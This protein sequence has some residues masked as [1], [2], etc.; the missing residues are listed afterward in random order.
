MLKSPKR[1]MVTSALPYANGPLHIGHLTGAY[2]PADIY[3]RYLRLKGEDVVWV[4]GSDEHGAAI[5]I[6]AMK[7][8]LTPREIIDKY[9]AMFRDAFEGMGISFDIFHRTSAPLHYKTSQDFFRKLH[10]KGEFE[11]I[12]NEQYFDEEKQTFL[13]DRY[14]IGTCPVCAN[15]DAYGDQCEKC[16]TSLSPNELKP[17]IRS[18]LS[19]SLPIKK[20]TKHWYLKLDTYEDWLKEWITQGVLET[21]EGK[22]KTHNPDDWK[23]HVLGQCKSWLEGGLHPRAM[24]RDLDWGIPVPEEID[25]TGQKKLYVWLDAPIGYISATRQWAHDKGDD[26]LW[27]KY[28]QDPDSAL[29]HFIGKDNIV[30]HCLIFPALLK[31]HGGYILPRNVPANQFMNLEGKKISTSRNWAVWV[32]EYLED[33]AGKQD[34]LR[35][36]MIKNM[37]EQRDSE[38]TW[39][40]FQDA[41]NGELVGNL[42]NFINRVLVLTGKFYDG[43]VPAFDTDT[44]IA[45]SQDSSTNATVA[46]E[47]NILKKRIT[48]IEQKIERFDFRG[49]LQ[50]LMEIST[51]GNQILQFNEPWKKAKSLEKQDSDV[52]AATLFLGI[53]IVAALSVACRPF[54]PFS[55][56]K[57][58]N[59]L[60]LS[61]LTDNHEWKTL[62][63]NLN[64]GFLLNTGSVL[65]TP[66]HLFERITDET[67]ALQ[68]E[69]L[70]ASEAQN[71][72]VLAAVAAP[73]FKPLAAE[74]T[75]DDFAKTDIRTGT[76]VSAEKVEKADKLLK[77]TIDLGFETRTVVS[78][79]AEHFS[80]DAIL[81]QQVLVLANLAPR[82]LRG[83]E[84]NG[85]ILMA[86]DA[87]G[88]LGFV[89]PPTGWSNGCVVK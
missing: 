15:P 1:Y 21:P 30:F 60:G 20:A 89:A 47:L 40:G 49:A 28:W 70:Q 2:L 7:E 25:Q 82:K 17:P 61:A 53:Q 23:A 44:P 10:E 34:V 73:V 77:L 6:R 66:E 29:I 16:G 4:C 76:I 72:P 67:I 54:L 13:A 55:S 37:P 78:G 81:G 80:P 31:Q 45:S 33:F 68:M 62:Q 18:T 19:G 52:A 24:T 27:E 57:I 79:I 65:G 14:I 46:E 71:T 3:V 85:M 36:Y 26:N 87:D 69:K 84:S 86:E 56:D 11:V 8:G 39:K 9:D 88:K 50:N 75:Y 5:T 32:H 41:N 83:I 38:F 64:T 43:K 74:I 48:D 63:Q 59:M 12:E 51:Q 42:A 58:R 22:I 35:Y